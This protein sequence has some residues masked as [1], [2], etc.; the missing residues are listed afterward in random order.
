MN[1]KSNDIY[2]YSRTNN[3]GSGTTICPSEFVNAEKLDEYFGEFEMIDHQKLMV[4]YQGELLYGTY[5]EPIILRTDS[6][7]W[8][9]VIYR[10]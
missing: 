3:I 6:E 8:R 7:A 4:F 9:S 2:L 1:I 10:N 5:Y